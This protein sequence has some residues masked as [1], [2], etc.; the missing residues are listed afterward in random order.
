VKRSILVASLPHGPWNPVTA[1]PPRR[2]G[3]VRRTTAIDQQRHGPG[4][5]ME[6]VA[7]GRDLRTAPDGTTTVVDEVRLEADIDLLG[8]VTSIRATPPEPALATLVGARTSRGFRALADAAVPE[9]VEGA[10]VLHQ[11]LDDVPTAGLISLYGST[12]DLGDDWDIPAESVEGLRDLCAGW[13]DG[14]TMLGAYDGTGVYPIPLGP[15]APDLADPGDALAWQELDALAP[16]SIRRRRRLDLIDGDVLELDVHF[17]DSHRGIEGGEE[18]L[19][20]YTV[21]ATVDPASLVVLSC[22]ASAH[23]L[24]WPECP[25][26]LAS[27]ARLVGEPVADLRSTV[28]TGF[29]GISTCTHLND[30]LRSVAGVPALA[31]ALR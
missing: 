17:R 27:A 5:P 25:N 10:T 2:P 3:S 1:T 4:Q 28:A 14:G 7:T 24:P 18:V 29:K 23:T 15:P 19:H 26:A 21:A 12:R 8:F 16:Q 22:E 30:V 11:L 20:E 6:L 9:H 31:G 13:I